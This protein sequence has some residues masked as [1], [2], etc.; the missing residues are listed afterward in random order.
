MK[1]GSAC[2]RRMKLAGVLDLPT[3]TPGGAARRFFS[4]CTDSAATRTA[5][6]ARRSPRCSP[7]W[8]RGAALRF[9]GCGE[10]EGERGRVICKEQVRDTRK[11]AVFSRHARRDRS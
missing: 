3:H 7:G 11:R 6:A 2:I 5:A 1:N 10:S 8:L 4:S 9:R